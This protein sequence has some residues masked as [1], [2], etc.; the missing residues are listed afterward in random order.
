MKKSAFIRARIE[1]N[2]KKEAEKIL[3][4]L[5]ITSSQ[6]VTMLYKHIIRKHEWPLELKIPNAKTEKSF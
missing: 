3:D 1:P 6:A 5:G 2:V 4:E